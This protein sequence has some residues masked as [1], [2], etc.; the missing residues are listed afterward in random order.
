MAIVFGFASYKAAITGLHLQ[1][2]TYGEDGTVAEA[3]DE[4]GYVEQQDVYGKKKTI[5]CEGNVVQ[6]GDLSA[7]KV[8]ADLTVDSVTYKINR[9]SVVEAVNGHK[10]ATIEGSAPMSAPGGGE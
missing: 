5:Q 8:G 1:K 6:G 7:L 2:V 4:D 3:L 10:V 9:L